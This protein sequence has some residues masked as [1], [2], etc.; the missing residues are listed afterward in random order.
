VWAEVPSSGPGGVSAVN[1]VGIRVYLSVG[2][3][4]EPPSDFKIVSLRGV[5][6]R[7]GHPVVAATVRNTGGRALD[8]SGQLRLSEGP[9]GLSA[10]PFAVELGTT[11]GVGQSE[12]VVSIL[13]RSVPA[14]PWTADMTLRSGLIERSAHARITFPARAGTSERPVR[15]VPDHA[16]AVLIPI[17]ATLASLVGLWLLLLLLAKRR[18]ENE[19][20][21]GRETPTA[22]GSKSRV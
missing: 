4:G 14:G 11:L 12:D 19:K 13:D 20:R 5:R 1:R 7:A 3:G 22:S 9:G 10:G 8:L 15:A 18:R 16:R 21:G 17:T 6:D 2:R